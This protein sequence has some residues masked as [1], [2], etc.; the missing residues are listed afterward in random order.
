MVLLSALSLPTQVQV[1]LGCD[2]ILIDYLLGT[3]WNAVLPQSVHTQSLSQGVISRM[4]HNCMISCPTININYKIYLI[5]CYSQLH[6]R[7]QLTLWLIRTGSCYHLI[8]SIH[9]HWLGENSR[10]WL[11]L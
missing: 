10:I 9:W 11:I 5:L 4:Y 7:S 3:C 6:F 2:N 1:E 8:G